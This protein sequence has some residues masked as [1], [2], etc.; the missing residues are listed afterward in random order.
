MTFRLHREKKIIFE[1]DESRGA[2]PSPHSTWEKWFQE[3]KTSASATPSTSASASVMPCLI[4]KWKPETLHCSPDQGFSVYCSP[5]QGR[6]SQTERLCSSAGKYMLTH[7]NFNQS[8]VEP[9][10]IGR[11]GSAPGRFPDHHLSWNACVHG[12]V[13]FGGKAPIS[14]H[15][16]PC[17]LHMSESPVFPKKYLLICGNFVSPPAKDD[18][19]PPAP[20][21]PQSCPRTASLSGNDLLLNLKKF[22]AKCTVR[23]SSNSS[24]NYNWTKRNVEQ[25]ICMN[26]SAGCHLT[27]VKMFTS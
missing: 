22:A 16:Y 9:A 24:E 20:P 3:L 27:A 10:K 26:I 4:M 25:L 23:L 21:T 19:K 12:F 6:G 14:T 1:T 5:S 8:S 18:P 15:L 17:C 11:Q 13:A 7:F 2:T